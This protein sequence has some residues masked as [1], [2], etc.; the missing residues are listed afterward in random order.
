MTEEQ[1]A[2]YLSDLDRAAAEYRAGMA[3]EI[4]PPQR[5]HEMKRTNR[6]EC[7]QWLEGQ[8]NTSRAIV[9]W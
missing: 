6:K 7:E 1:A 4:L 3:G 9:T 5:S 8:A 2:E